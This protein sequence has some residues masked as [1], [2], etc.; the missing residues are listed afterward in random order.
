MEAAMRMLIVVMVLLMSSVSYIYADRSC[1]RDEHCPDYYSCYFGSCEFVDFANEETI[2][3]TV[4]EGFKKKYDMII[5]GYEVSE[6]VDNILLGAVSIEPLESAGAYMIKR[7]NIYFEKSE[8]IEIRNVRLVNDVNK[9]GEFD[10]G[11]RVIMNEQEAQTGEFTR[12]IEYVKGEEVLSADEDVNLL[13]VADYEVDR[14]SENTWPAFGKIMNIGSIEFSKNVKVSANLIKNRE[15]DPVAVEPWGDVLFFNT[16]NAKLYPDSY[17]SRLQGITISS[18]GRVKMIKITFSATSSYSNDGWG[19]DPDL[20]AEGEKTYLTL[21]SESEGIKTY[22]T[23]GLSEEKVFE[24][25]YWFKPDEPVEMVIESEGM[26]CGNTYS[27]SFYSDAV[28]ITSDSYQTYGLPF[29]IESPTSEYDDACV[30]E[31][32]HYGCSVTVF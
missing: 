21:K 22:S 1:M 15:F 19:G 3:L 13:V 8:N 31:E 30:V 16:S 5:S 25:G 4:K 7:L 11:D 28:E 23:A 18:T 17:G 6:T 12:F 26:I 10:Y 32:K 20:E 2:N 14:E 29:S 9:N 24:V 27:I